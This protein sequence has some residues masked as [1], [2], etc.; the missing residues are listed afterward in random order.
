LCEISTTSMR[1]SSAISIGSGTMRRGPANCTGEARSENCGSARM[2][3]PPSWT[4][5]AE[6][7]IQVTVGSDALA[8]NR[9]A[10]AFTCG[11]CQPPGGGF[12]T[13]SRI[14]SH[15]HTQKLCL[16]SCG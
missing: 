16:E 7:P 12:G 8:R 9:S 15:F 14:C 10:S 1:G 13:P 3:T 6:C 11:I 5:N 4:R 2:L